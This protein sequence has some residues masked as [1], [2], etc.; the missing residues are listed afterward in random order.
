MGSTVRFWVNGKQVAAE[1]DGKETLLSFLREKLHLM[2]TKNG[3]GTG[4]CGACTVIIDGKARRSCAVRLARMEGARIETIEGLA[5]QGQLH[6]IQSAF[7][8]SG[9]IQCGFCTPGMILSA[10]ALLDQNPNPDPEEIT[11][12]LEHH[13][14]RCTGYVKIFDAVEAASCLLGEGESS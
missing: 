13:L 5:P 9:A 6:P 10:K 1:P 14:C 11:Q 7:L 4:H 3:C 2:G 12:A 8:R